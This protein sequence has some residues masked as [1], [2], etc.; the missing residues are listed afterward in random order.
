MR[1]AEVYSLICLDSWSHPWD[2]LASVLPGITQ[3]AAAWACPAYADD[4][5]TPADW[6]KPGSI[7]WQLNHILA[8]KA[9]YTSV[10]RAMDHDADADT[11]PLHDLAQLKA[12]LASA[13]E[14]YITALLERSDE[15]FARVIGRDLT[16]RAFID[17]NLRHEIWHAG[18]IAVLKRLYRSATAASISPVGHESD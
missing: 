2:S 13:G 5:E 4:I 16:L 7:L 15:D 1:I 8:C 10:L 17:S 18:Q 6:P 3:E 14:A 11:P 12:A 9:G